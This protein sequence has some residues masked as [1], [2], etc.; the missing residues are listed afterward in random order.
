MN[1][2]LPALLESYFTRRLMNQ[3][4]VSTHTLASY[5]DTFRL[6]LKFAAERG[7]KRPADLLLADLAAPTIMEF[8]DNLEAQRHCAISSRNQ[9]LAAIRSFFHYVAVEAPQ[10]AG[11]IQRVLAIPGKRTVRRLIGF[12][13]R[14]EITRRRGGSQWLAR[15]P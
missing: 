1:P 3:R 14:E 7:H 8:L 9:R 6:L 13:A 4:K 12:L 2:E 5:R 10:Q 15:T 11:L